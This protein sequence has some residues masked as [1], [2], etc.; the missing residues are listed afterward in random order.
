MPYGISQ[1]LKQSTNKWNDKEWIEREKRTDLIQQWCSPKNQ[2]EGWEKRDR[3]MRNKRLCHVQ[4]PNNSNQCKYYMSKDLKANDT[5]R[6]KM[7]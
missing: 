6:T 7:V 4:K 5:A 2:R 3:E 1:W